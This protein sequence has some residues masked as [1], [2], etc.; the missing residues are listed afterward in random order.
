MKSKNYPLIDLHIE[1]L[2]TESIIKALENDKLDAGILVTPLHHKQIIERTL[3]NEPFY[4]YASNSHPFHKKKQIYPKDLSFDDVRLSLGI[5][6]FNVFNNRNIY[7][8]YP[9]TGDPNTRSEYYTKEIN[10]PVDGGTISNSYY[11]VPWHFS[12]PREI[13]FFIQINYK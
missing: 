2:K 12:S 8:V 4:I 7:N 6:I 3:F 1:E 13:N 9:E 10:L 11:D 5:N